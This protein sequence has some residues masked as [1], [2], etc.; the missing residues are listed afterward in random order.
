MDFYMVSERFLNSIDSS[1]MTGSEVDKG[2]S[3]VI[4]FSSPYYLHPS[5]SLKQ[6]SV[7]EVLTDGN[8]NDWAREMTNFLFA[9]NKTD[10]VDGTLK[11]PKT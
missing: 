9:K 7:N 2:G 10:F 3:S 5:D 11:K 1:I 6:P 4:D 8:Y